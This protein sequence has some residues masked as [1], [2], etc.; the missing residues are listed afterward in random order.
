LFDLELLPFLRRDFLT[1]LLTQTVVVA[2]QIFFFQIILIEMSEM[3]RDELLMI[4]STLNLARVDELVSLLQETDDAMILKVFAIALPS[5]PTQ[6]EF[7]ALAIALLNIS[8]PDTV[9]QLIRLIVELFQ[10]DK[11]KLMLRLLVELEKTKTIKRED[12]VRVIHNLSGSQLLTSCFLSNDPETITKI[13]EYYHQNQFKGTNNIL[14]VYK[15]DIKEKIDFVFDR[16][17]FQNFYQEYLQELEKQE[18][19]ALP[20]FVVKTK[21]L[22]HMIGN[23]SINDFIQMDIMKD[24]I[25]IYSL[26]HFECTKRL[27]SIQN[28]NKHTLI[29]KTIFQELFRL[30]KTSNKPIYYNTLM[31]TLCRENLDKIPKAFAREFKKAFERIDE[32]DVEIMKRLVDFFSIHLSN[33]GFYWNWDQYSHLLPKTTNPEDLRN[34]LGD[35]IVVDQVEGKKLLFLKETFENLTRLSY[36]SRIKNS[37]PEQFDC[38]FPRPPT[39]TYTIVKSNLAEFQRELDAKIVQRQ[40]EGVIELLGK[41]DQHLK[42]F[43]E[44]T[45]DVE[46]FTSIKTN[47]N[48]IKECFLQSVLF[49]GSKSF[50]HLLNVIEK[51]LLLLKTNNETPVMQKQTVEVIFGFWKSNTQFLEVCLG[52]FIN[53]Q[54]VGLKTVI[55]HVMSVDFVIENYQKF[56]MWNILKSMI[57]KVLLRLEQL[58]EGEGDLEIQIEECRTEKREVFVL[59]FQVLETN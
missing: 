2:Q 27:L 7:L 44:S 23:E 25:D 16:R 21:E 6:I 30:P 50:S 49:Q 4:F 56:F 28:Q 58:E 32:M 48:L 39:H 40:D 3:E 55:E 15:T 17:D 22:H 24:V 20:K 57:L 26:N 13:Q 11:Q 10:T 47:E 12:L 29:V 33:F 36:H 46:L 18:P 35:E 51:Y 14:K 19:Q 41:I 1:H 37:I 5:M 34:T 53:Y 31:T 9:K 42:S 38:I 43:P 52:K 59:V 8:K 54:I 45:K